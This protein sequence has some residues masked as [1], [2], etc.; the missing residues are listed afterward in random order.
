MRLWPGKRMRKSADRLAQAAD[1]VE[2]ARRALTDAEGRSGEAAALSARL[3]IM[4]GE[5]HF[6]LGLE[7]MIRTGY[8]GGRSG[9]GG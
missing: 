4:R 5:N 2:Q 7:N 9:A 3:R 1:A 8:K 6:A